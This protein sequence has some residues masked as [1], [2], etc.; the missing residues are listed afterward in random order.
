MRISQFFAL[1]FLCCAAMAGAA[2]AQTTYP[3]H[4]RAGGNMSVN[5]AG[6]ATG[7]SAEL[8]ISYI[9]ATATTGLVPGSCTWLDR[10]MNSR[11]PQAMRLVLRARMNVDLRPRPGDHASDRADTFVYAGSGPDVALATTIMSTLE[12]GGYFTVQAHNPE[13]NPCSGGRS[14]HRGESILPP[15]WRGFTPQNVQAWRT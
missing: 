5:I 10:T 3:L 14:C 2:N 7:G 15:P 6:Q 12:S 9:R 1:V 4:C 11:E 13:D 8:V